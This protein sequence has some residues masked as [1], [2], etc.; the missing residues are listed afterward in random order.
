M[1]YSPVL[2]LLLLVSSCIFSEKFPLTIED[3][4]TLSIYKKYQDSLTLLS[5][6]QKTDTSENV[7]NTPLMNDSFKITQTRWTICTGVFKDQQNA[8]RQ[9]WKISKRTT[10]FIMKRNNLHFVT[11]GSFTSLDSAVQFQKITNMG[12]TYILKVNPNEKL[13]QGVSDTTLE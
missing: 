11:A 2:L 3:I 8:H 13:V 10:A 5:S 6:V 9:F 12:N 4:D 1:K 7:L